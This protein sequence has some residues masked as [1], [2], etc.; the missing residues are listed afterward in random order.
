[1]NTL[2][3]LFACMLFGLLGN[4]SSRSLVDFWLS[5]GFLEAASVPGPTLIHSCSCTIPAAAGRLSYTPLA[6][7]VAC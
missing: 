6:A 5:L 3:M 4:V 2:G 1:M 7:S